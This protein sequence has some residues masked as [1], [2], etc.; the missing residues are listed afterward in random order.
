MPDHNEDSEFTTLT[1]PT[2]EPKLDEKNPKFLAMVERILQGQI[3]T[4][5]SVGRVDAIRK[6]HQN[7]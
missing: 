3:D 2:D 6:L 5:R 1:L 7:E 4:G